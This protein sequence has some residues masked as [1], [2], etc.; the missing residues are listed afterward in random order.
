MRPVGNKR[1]DVP[2]TFG[3]SD[4]CRVMGGFLRPKVKGVDRRNHEAPFI[5]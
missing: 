5:S 4:E 1:L 2:F 3:K